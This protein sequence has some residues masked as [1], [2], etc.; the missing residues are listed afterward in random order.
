MLLLNMTKKLKIIGVCPFCKRDVGNDMR[1]INTLNAE[2]AQKLLADMDMVNC[3]A[4]TSGLQL[5][6][7][8]VETNM[9]M[10]E[11]LSSN[12]NLTVTLGDQQIS[13]KSSAPFTDTILNIVKTEFERPRATE[14]SG[15]EQIKF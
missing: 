14:V 13:L 9:N 11:N 5:S 2:N 3:E 10:N 8:S 7:N 15:R 6:S 12:S 4:S 1:P